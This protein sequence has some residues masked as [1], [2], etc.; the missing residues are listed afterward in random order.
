MRWRKSAKDQTPEPTVASDEADSVVAT[1]G[2][3]HDDSLNENGPVVGHEPVATPA[4][5]VE[6]PRGAHAKKGGFVL[7]D[8]T[9]GAH[10]MKGDPLLAVE[11]RA[12]HA[13][14]GE[15]LAEEPS[16]TPTVATGAPVPAGPADEVTAQDDVLAAEADS[17]TTK[18][19]TARTKK[20]KARRSKRLGT[21]T[22]PTTSSGQAVNAK[23]PHTSEP[24]G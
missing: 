16:E 22:A 15:A 10:V 21:D 8:E 5:P 13:K 1:S 12:L 9:P 7:P 11:G 3:A 17:L 24:H 4:E 2:S 18:R 20:R 6:E 14:K 19:R 23:T